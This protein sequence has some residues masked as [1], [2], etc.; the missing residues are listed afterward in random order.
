MVRSESPSGRQLKFNSIFLL[1]A[2]IILSGWIIYLVSALPPSYRAR[3]WDLA[4]VGFDCAMLISLM[5]TSW[6]MWKRRQIAIPGAMVSAT[7]LIIDSWFDVVT[8]NQGV[9]F[10]IA[11]AS[12]LLIEIP[13]AILLFRFSRASVRRS[14]RNAHVQA[15]VA[16]VSVSLWRTP[17]MIFERD[18]E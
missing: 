17:L 13:S 7:F 9:D 16:I 18:T 15:G 6:A 1:I 14:I 8:S 10:N 5:T 4:W 12:A 3:H 2:S 11:I